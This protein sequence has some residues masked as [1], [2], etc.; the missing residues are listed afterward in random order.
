MTKTPEALKTYEV[1]GRYPAH[2]PQRIGSTVRLTEETAR[3]HVMSGALT[4]KT[5][6]LAAETTAK[7]KGGDK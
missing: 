5:P 7:R 2:R 3:Y 4:E 6:P 1:T